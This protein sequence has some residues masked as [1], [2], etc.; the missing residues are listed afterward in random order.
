MAPEK[1]TLAT[2]ADAAPAAR[3][4]WV[5]PAWFLAGAYPSNPDVGPKR[6]E[7]VAA[8]WKAGIRTFVN[9]VEEDERP[10]GKPFTV[11]ADDLD[12]IAA[13]EPSEARASC[14]RFPV[15]DAGI[16]SVSGMRSVLDTID[17][18]LAAGRPVYLH[19]F[20]GMGRTATAV[21]CWLLRHGLASSDDVL[22]VITRLRQADE[23]RR[24]WDAPEN[25]AQ[26]AL[27]KAWLRG[28]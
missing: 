2:A 28:C 3:S 8:L 5:V 13:R 25:D 9:L 10:W 7:R 17:L 22:D 12:E 1:Q 23:E 19:C 26:R 16:P 20:G 24:D 11:Y 18:S 6:S 15:R 21:G 27:A 14:I 4:Y